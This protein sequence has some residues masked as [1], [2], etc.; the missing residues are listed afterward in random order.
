MDRCPRILGLRCNFLNEFDRG[1]ARLW[2]AAG[3]AALLNAEQ[4]RGARTAAACL[5]FG[6]FV[7]FDFAIAF[8]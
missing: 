2:R 1:Y 6:R 3:Y 8:K 4:S 5:W 7:G